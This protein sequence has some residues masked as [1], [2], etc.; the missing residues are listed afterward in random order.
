MV[1]CSAWYTNEISN[2]DPELLALCPMHISF[3]RQNNITH[4]VFTRPTH[5]GQRSAAAGLLE[6][7]EAKVSAAVEAGIAAARR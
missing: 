2:I 6:G 4:I 7:L 5:V 1:F 3:Y